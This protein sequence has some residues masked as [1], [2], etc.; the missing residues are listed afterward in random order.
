MNDMFAG[1]KK[2]CKEKKLTLNF[3]KTNFMEF[4]NNNKSIDL[5]IGYDKTMEKVVNS[6]A[7]RLIT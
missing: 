2:W 3:Y 5:N 4:V 7:C 6:L 1:L